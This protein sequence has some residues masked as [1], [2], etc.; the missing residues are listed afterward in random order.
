MRS[1]KLLRGSVVGGAR[2]LRDVPRFVR[3]AETGQ[4]RFGVM[5][6]NRITLDQVN[7]GIDRLRRAEGMRTVIA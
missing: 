3:L 2:I 4:L 7:A 1:G 6:S 5:V